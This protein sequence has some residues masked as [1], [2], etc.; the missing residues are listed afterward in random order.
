MLGRGVFRARRR[1]LLGVQQ[2]A[3]HTLPAQVHRKP[4][5][6]SVMTLRRVNDDNEGGWYHLS[7]AVR[8]GR[9][10]VCR[11]RRHLATKSDH[12]CGTPE[13][14]PGDIDWDLVLRRPHAPDADPDADRTTSHSST[15]SENCTKDQEIMRQLCQIKTGVLER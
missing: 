6:A 15:V 10:F 5:A 4:A 9:V 11:D 1:L 8:D 7:L 13:W 2:Q 12:P 3:G 14:S